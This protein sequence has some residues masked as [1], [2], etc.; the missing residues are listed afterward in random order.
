ML[1]ALSGNVNIRPA[2]IV[3]VEGGNAERVMSI[4]PVDVSLGRDICKRA[5]TAIF[6]QNILRAGQTAWATHHS[7]TFP[8]ASTP[9]ARNRGRGRIEVH[10]ICNYQIQTPVAV[11]I[12]EG[13]SGSPG[14]SCSSDT[15]LLGHFG[16]Y[17]MV[18]VIQAIFS[19]I[20][21]VQVFPT[22]IV[23]VTDA[24]SLAPSCSDQAG[25]RGDIG[26]GPIMIVVIEM[27][28][29]SLVRGKPLECGSIH[30]EN[31]RPPVI[32]IIK[33]GHARPGGLNDVLLGINAAKNIHCC[34]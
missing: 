26:K 5:V 12:D 13:T 1:G 4:G 7:H 19:I 16:E 31:I 10:I 14:L 17:A 6:V 29:G 32:V 8:H 27:V 34:Q 18:I 23:I 11:V 33:D 21:D 3:E 28:G 22:I 24:Y 15:G 25:F 20:G 30:N 2:I 9:L